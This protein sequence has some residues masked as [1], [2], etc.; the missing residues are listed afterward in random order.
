[1]A[2]KV[3]R[4][5]T[6]G[7]AIERERV[8]SKGVVSLSH[9]SQCERTA[10]IAVESVSEDREMAGKWRTGYAE[11]FFLRRLRGV[12]GSRGDEEEAEKESERCHRQISDCEGEREKYGYRCEG[13]SALMCM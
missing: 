6:L 11:G 9:N 4:Y 10:C 12:E 1:M 3:E 7:A 8:Q 13:R 5:T 2:A